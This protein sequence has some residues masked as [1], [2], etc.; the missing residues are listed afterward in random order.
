MA[1]ARKTKAA[2]SGK[3]A[4][5]DLGLSKRKSANVRGGGFG[6]IRELVSVTQDKVDA[7]NQA[8]LAAAQKQTGR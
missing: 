6:G 7:A 1:K 3:R 5:R 8:A 2:G 4:V